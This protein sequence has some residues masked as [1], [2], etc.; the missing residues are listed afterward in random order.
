MFQSFDEIADPTLGAGR[1]ARLRTELERRGLTGFIVPRADEHQGE[2]VP[3]GAE[4]L[5]WL[6][7]F[8]GSAGVAVVLA[9]RAAIFVD[10]RY[11]LQAQ[12]Q[13]DTTV[14]EPV[15]LMANP[16]HV[17]LKGA[18]AAGDRLG[19]DPWLTTVA[20]ARR[21]RETC[22]AIGAEL[23]A[24]DGN[25]IDAIWADRPDVPLGPVTCQP[26]ELAGES[27]ASKLARVASIL[28]DKNVDAAVLTQ[29]DSVA[30]TFNI[31]GSDIPHTPVALAFSILPRDGRPR[32]F[33]DGRKLGNAERDHLEAHADVAKPAAFADGLDKL[34]G[35]R[36]LIDESSAAE[37]IALR[38]KAAGGT[39]VAGDD[40]VL[41]PKA[42][43]N[44]S[45]IEG[46]RAAHRRDGAAFVHFLAWFDAAASVISD[47]SGELD[48]IAVVE[49]L[50]G[51]R[52]Q[53]GQLVDISFDTISG[54]GPNGAIVHYRVS[55][56]TNRAIAA[57]SLFLIDSGGQYRDG[58]TD[59][60]RT[61][62]VGM[63]TTEM[64]DRFTRV[65]KG[66]IAISIARFPIGTIGAQLDSLAR[67]ALWQAGL[68][69]DHGTG[70]GVGSF[71]SVH[72]GPQR[73]SKTG[74]AP[75]EPGMIISN[76]P[77][78]YR[79]DHFGIR[80]ENLILVE[81][82]SVP[83]GGERPMLGFE[84]LT[85]APIDRRLIEATLLTRAELKWLDAYH[86][87]VRDVLGP[88]LDAETR[89]WLEKATEPLG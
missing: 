86:A 14:F 49:A 48:E 67:F 34:A 77:G 57:P 33:I 44:A 89:D 15:D 87:R 28:A 8:S 73:I 11:T 43:K 18:L 7:G 60:T 58:T 22:A 19:Y 83:D 12:A 27:V 16:P 63:P 30:W 38:I 5:R 10:G 35:A 4:R 40:P 50:E 24:V 53:T 85:L 70:H 13:C 76:E 3:P 68:D 29:T 69:Y 32:L 80:I 26:D 20:S 56:A 9:N 84:T 37:A 54:A 88:L 31:R 59:I 78:Y 72:E 25:P 74:T 75:L 42:R 64:R 62:P 52:R 79:P 23:V 65:L 81:P 51:F 82:A 17:W 2:Y 47:G 21:L 36:V 61:L 55:R 6:T 1:A 71:L 41:L 46:T 66:M 45:E 39:L